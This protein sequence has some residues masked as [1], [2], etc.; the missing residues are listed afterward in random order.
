[1][2]KAIPRQLLFSA[3]QFSFATSSHSSPKTKKYYSAR[4]GRPT[5][6]TFLASLQTQKS[7]TLQKS[8]QQALPTAPESMMPHKGGDVF[9]LLKFS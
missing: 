6:S 1:M 3:H 7:T 5:I 2:H 4:I 9:S 8:Q